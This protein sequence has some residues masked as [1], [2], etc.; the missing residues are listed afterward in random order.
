MTTVVLGG[1]GKTGRRLV[2]ALGDAPVRAVSRSTEVRFDWSDQD[3]WPA[4]LEGA[5]SVY[6]VASEDPAQTEAFVKQ[7][8]AAGVE[9]FVALSGRGLDHVPPPAFRSMVAAEAAVRES[10]VEWTILRANNFSQNFSEE[11][12]HGPLVAG[13]LALPMGDV[14]EPFVDVRDIADVAAA[15]LTT[16]GHHGRVY[17]LSG[18]AALTFAEAVS[19]IASVAGLDTRYEEVTPSEYRAMLLASGLPGEVA[20]ELNAMFATMRAGHLARPADGVRQVLGRE[21]IDFADYAAHA[22]AAGAWR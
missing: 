11:V 2:T 21:P 12:W 17:D 4:V 3:T 9:R 13:R 15:V 6:L 7:A 8:V 14:P 22:A 20:D 5:R 19:T 18:P 1:T 16:D 10:G